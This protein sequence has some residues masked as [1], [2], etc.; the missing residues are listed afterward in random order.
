MKDLIMK[1]KILVLILM[2]IV[3]AVGVIAADTPHNRPDFL[4]NTYTNHNQNMASVVVLDN[5]NFI[6]T[7]TSEVQDEA[8][9]G[10]YA[11]IFNRSG[12][13]IGGEIHVPT[14]E[15]NN[16]RWS[17]AVKL[18]NGNF[19]I[20]WMVYDLNGF[21]RAI[22]AQTF[23]PDGNKIFE[24]K[25]LT[26]NNDFYSPLYDITPYNYYPAVVAVDDGIIVA[27]TEYRKNVT[28]GYEIYAQKFNNRL[29]PIAEKIKVNT[30]DNGNQENP[31]IAV[32]P[33][34]KVMIVWQTI[35]AQSSDYANVSIS[36]QMLDSDVNLIGGEFRVNPVTYGSHVGA[37]VNALNNG[38]F[39]VTWTNREY[40]SPYTVQSLGQIFNENGMPITKGFKANTN[41]GYNFQ[42]TNNVPL[43]N[44]GFVVVW[45]AV[46]DYTKGYEVWAQYYNP[47]YKKMGAQF[48]VN[49]NQTN[50]YQRTPRYPAVA[51]FSDDGF[52]S[53][54]NVYGLVE[55]SDYNLLDVFGQIYNW[56][57]IRPKK[58]V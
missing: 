33:L 35:L 11:Q 50:V 13:K 25:V 44:G 5:D 22:K 47:Q 39:L 43:S 12:E 40:T 29:F 49:V 54:Y 46:Y 52:V 58:V 56:D 14:D 3:S 6:V 1:S 8:G 7:W 45:D 15:I 26:E 27:W 48:R 28:N 38:N 21:G 18:S 37:Y 24:E 57:E 51:A 41:T 20:V 55:G 9:D 23:T 4:V 53:A 16:E 19:V 30:C 36:G 31:T 2:L 42:V 17:K 10:V 32:S 34:G